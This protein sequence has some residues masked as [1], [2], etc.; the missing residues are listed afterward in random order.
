MHDTAVGLRIRRD[1]PADSKRLF[2]ALFER[3]ETIEQRF[4]HPLE[5]RPKE[6]VKVCHIVH[7]IDSGGW[8]DEELWPEVHEKMVDAMVRLEQALAPEIER[9]P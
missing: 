9:L 6:D 1:T 5:W 4:G 2:D 3:R 7:P 8:K